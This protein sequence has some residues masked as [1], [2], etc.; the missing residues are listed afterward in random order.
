MYI[1][2][3]HD[4]LNNVNVFAC[5]D[6]YDHKDTLKAHGFRWNPLRKEWQ[7]NYSTYTE[8]T[9]TMVDTMIACS[10]PYDAFEDL[11]AYSGSDIQNAM[12]DPANYDP[13]SVE[14]FNAAY[15]E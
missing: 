8:L 5:M 12:D 13:A 4:D 3:Y 10:L 15:G 2:A 6:A 7:K 1:R 14:K 11:Y 9:T